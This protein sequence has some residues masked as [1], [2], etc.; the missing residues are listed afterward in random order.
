MLRITHPTLTR[1]E[2]WTALRHIHMCQGMW[3]RRAL[4]AC[5]ACYIPDGAPGASVCAGVLQ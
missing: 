3:C 4:P 1:Q 5:G 2:G